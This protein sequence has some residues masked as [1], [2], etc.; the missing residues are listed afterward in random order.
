MLAKYDMG[1][2]TAEVYNNLKTGDVVW[3]RVNGEC[4]SQKGRIVFEDKM[5]WFVH[6]KAD[7]EKDSKGVEIGEWEKKAMG[8]YA[9]LNGR[10]YA[11]FKVVVADVE[12]PKPENKS[13][14]DRISGK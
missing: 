1:A 12:Q 13:L 4:Y 2:L 5:P 11:E 6:E 7:L 8:W 9:S 14:W 10:I 3:Y